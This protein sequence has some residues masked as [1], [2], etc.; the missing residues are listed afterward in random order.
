MYVSIR[1]VKFPEISNRGKNGEEAN[2]KR[3][4]KN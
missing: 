3:L 4:K 2:E 1:D